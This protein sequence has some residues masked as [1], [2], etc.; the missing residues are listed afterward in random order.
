MAWNRV[1]QCEKNVGSISTSYRLI[2]FIIVCVKYV[3]DWNCCNQD[4][5]N[6]YVHDNEVW[7]TI[8][9]IFNIKEKYQEVSNV[10]LP[11]ISR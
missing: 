2:R 11:R 4:V 5:A 10:M 3:T 1:A 9:E 7:H 6:I 8:D